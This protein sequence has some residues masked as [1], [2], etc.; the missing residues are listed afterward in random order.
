LGVVGYGAYMTFRGES[1]KPPLFDLATAA[2]LVDTGD[3]A[4]AL[5]RHIGPALE[6]DPKDTAALRLKERC[7]ASPTPTPDPPPTPPGPTAADVLL[8]D[9]D[10]LLA[11]NQKPANKEC[12]AALDKVNE[13][14]TTDPTN[15]RALALKKNVEACQQPSALAKRTPQG[16]IESTEPEKGGLKPLDK[17][18]PEAHASRVRI[19]VAKVDDAQK[20]A[21]A[22]DYDAAEKALSGVPLP[23]NFKGLAEVLDSIRAGKNKRQA[24]ELLTEARTAVARNDFLSG[25]DLYR[26]AKELDDSLPI[27]KEL[28]DVRS[29]RRERAQAACKRAA[30]RFI[31]NAD[32]ARTLYGDALTLLRPGELCYDDAVQRSK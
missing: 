18:T 17:E 5:V 9:A 19:A 7:Q 14:L 32:Q 10:A 6:Q 12:Q 13:V 23:S 31:S 25:E 22:G 28:D 30:A 8:N 26:R 4:D 11:S 29:R 20:R 3:C 16:W 24:G 1:P 15:E 21:A 2:K 27:D